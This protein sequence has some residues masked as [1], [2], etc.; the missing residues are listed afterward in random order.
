MDIK[1]IIKNNKYIQSNNINKSNNTTSGKD[2]N[3]LIYLI[4]RNI[5]QSN[6]IKL[7][8]AMESIL[9]D[10]ILSK[11]KDLV[12][13]KPLN[14]KDKKEK[15]HLFMDDINKIIYYAEVKSNLNLDTEKSKSTINKCIQIKSELEQQYQGYII[16]M[17]LLGLRYY[18]KDI[19][20]NNIRKKYV[21]IDEN[22]ISV[23]E[24]FK[25]LNVDIT[26]KTEEEYIELLN[27][28]VDCI[29]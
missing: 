11:N 14:E 8:I 10:I 21:S 19:M 2:F 5:S 23:N 26:F 3:S 25:N 6:C 1:D 28:V 17:Y 12:N 16:K 7:G 4:N 29:C 24:Y 18:N 13:I 22:V 27:Y 20:P 9:R 15:D